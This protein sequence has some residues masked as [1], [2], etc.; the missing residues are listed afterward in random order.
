MSVFLQVF[1]PNCVTLRVSVLELPKECGNNN[2]GVG[3][4]G[5]GGDGGSGG[6]G[7]GGERVFYC[8]T[9]WPSGRFHC[10]L[11]LSSLRLSPSTMPCGFFPAL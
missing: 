7:G 3:R 9:D 2:F 5:G 8:L 10:Q 11:H 6:G 4:G 1:R